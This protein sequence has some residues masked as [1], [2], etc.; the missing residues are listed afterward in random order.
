MQTAVYKQCLFAYY[1]IFGQIGCTFALWQKKFISGSQLCYCG[2]T[3]VNR[4]R[5]GGRRGAGAE[6]GNFACRHFSLNAAA[7]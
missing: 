7:D 2:L 5:T 3:L 4:E 1:R 6:E